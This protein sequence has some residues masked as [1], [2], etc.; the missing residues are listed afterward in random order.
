MPLCCYVSET[1]AG[2]FSW[3][4]GRMSGNVPLT[5]DFYACLDVR[6]RRQYF[7]SWPI[8]KRCGIIETIEK[9][10]TPTRSILAP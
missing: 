8:E 7:H 10:P 3:N 6:P 9:N 5:F 4:L 1:L 2:W